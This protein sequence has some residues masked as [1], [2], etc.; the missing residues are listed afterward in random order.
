LK[1]EGEEKIIKRERSKTKKKKKKR[2]L[3]VLA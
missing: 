3:F 1:E 2:R